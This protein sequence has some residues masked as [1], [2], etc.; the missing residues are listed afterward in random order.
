MQ[1][2]YRKYSVFLLSIVLSFPAFSQS[3]SSRPNILFCIADDA[4]LDHISA[5]GK[6]KWVRT[7]A[8]DKVAAQGL[9][10]TN[11]YTPNA[12]CSPSRASIL[13][14]RNPW[15]LEAA[16]NHFPY[17]PEKFTTFMESLLINGYSTGSTGKGWS[18]GDA[19]TKDGKPRLLTG[20]KYNAIKTEAPTK[21][22]TNLDYAAN[23]KAFLKEKKEGQPFCFWFG[24][25]EPHRP[26]AYGSGINKG[27]KKL[28]DIEKVPPYWID[29]EKV[30]T[31][32]LDYAFEVEYFDKQLQ[33]F[34]TI[35][36]ENGELENTIIVV[37]SD[38]GM[39]FPRVKGHVYEQANHLPLAIMWKQGIKNAGRKVDNM[40][41]FIDLAPTFLELA[42][43]SEKESNMQPIEGRS[44]I[45]IFKNNN[46]SNKE[47]EFVLLGRE[48][49]DVGRPN[50]QGYPV[51]SI[52]KNNLFYTYNYEPE[53][54]PS[55]NPETGY[56]DTDSSPTKT[57]I[58][59]A[60]RNGEHKDIWQLN[61]GKKGKEELYDLSKDPFCMTNLASEKSYSKQ[62]ENLKALMETELKKQGDPRM[63]GNGEVFDKYP[64]ASDAKDFYNRYMKGEREGKMNRVKN[65]ID[66]AK[67]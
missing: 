53:R 65:D 8:F 58:L 47:Q 27:N 41:S 2:Y 45:P 42:S 43:V 57:V 32:M 63:F 30:R 51:R 56:Q 66:P 35:L 5:Y 13:T 40:V 52:V 54:W 36:E 1:F 34:L 33:Q 4:S 28:S 39:P 19:G 18:P 10:F 25:N 59:D 15:Q 38:N 11:A 67:P 55:S 31:D 17:F 48:R 22:M 14:G 16:G 61:F 64:S 24:A 7:P 20:K 60:N 62:K 21:A 49:T 12:K 50:D 9:L 6:L 46:K 26:Y 23:F 3:K 44:L 29:N 37:T